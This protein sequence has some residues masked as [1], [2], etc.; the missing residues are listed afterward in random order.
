LSLFHLRINALC[1]TVGYVQSWHKH[2]PV[3]AFVRDLS[4]LSSSLFLSLSLSLLILSL[5]HSLSLS[6]DALKCSKFFLP[7]RLRWFGVKNVFL[8]L[9][10]QLFLRNK[11]AVQD[12]GLDKRESETLYP[13]SSL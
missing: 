13:I 12:E 6:Y 11:I 8:P 4:V 5:P 10:V 2:K 1:V 3:N 9:G 7:F